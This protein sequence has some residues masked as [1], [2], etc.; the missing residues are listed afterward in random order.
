MMIK[1][2]PRSETTSSKQYASVLQTLAAIGSSV[3]MQDVICSFT[4]VVLFALIAV[5]YEFLKPE[6]FVAI[7]GLTENLK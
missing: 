6:S 1:V 3:T 7:R 2:F 5:G 4:S